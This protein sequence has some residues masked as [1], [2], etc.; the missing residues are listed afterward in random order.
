MYINKHYIST[1]ML[2]VRLVYR[3]DIYAQRNYYCFSEAFLHKSLTGERMKKIK[4]ESKK[5]IS[6]MCV[7]LVEIHT[8]LI[9]I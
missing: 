4:E 3:C 5:V 1:T 6:V 2:S 7:I 8:I 9:L